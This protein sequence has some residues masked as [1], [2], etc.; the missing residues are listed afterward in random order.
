MAKILVTSLNPVWHQF[1]DSPYV[2]PAHEKLI[3]ELTHE[4][5]QKAGS[6]AVLEHA[7]GWGRHQVARVLNE[8]QVSLRISNLKS[9]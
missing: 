9:F 8:K 7:T 1:G 3:I 6:K 4:A 5:L 2:K